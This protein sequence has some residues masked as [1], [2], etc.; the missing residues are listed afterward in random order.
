MPISDGLISARQLCS[1]SI[2]NRVIAPDAITDVEI[3]A[4]FAFVELVTTLPVSGNFEGRMVY[5]TTDDKLYRHDGSAFLLAVDG[6]DITAATISA[7]SMVA[8]TLT[9][10]EIS[11]GAIGASEL[12]AINI[13]VAKF[14]RSTTY[15]PGS[16]GWSID[17]DGTAEFQDVTVRGTI[18]A[19]S[20]EGNVTLGT[21]GVFRTAASG[22]RLEIT[23][24]AD[25]RVNFYSAAGLMGHIGATEGASDNLKIETDLG[26][27]PTLFLS[28]SGSTRGQVILQANGEDGDSAVTIV[29][30]GSSTHAIGLKVSGFSGAGFQFIL[31]DHLNNNWGKLWVASEGSAARP[32]YTWAGDDDTGMLRKTANQI[33]WATG[34]TERTFLTSGGFK[35]TTDNA[36]DLG[37]SAVTWRRLYVHDIYDETGVRRIQTRGDPGLLFYNESGT[38]RMSVGGTNVTFHDERFITSAFTATGSSAHNATV[39]DSSTFQEYR[40]TSHRKM[41]KNIRTMDP[42]LSSR[43]H[44]LDLRTFDMRKSYQTGAPWAD[45]DQHGMIADEVHKVFGDQAAAPD[46]NGEPGGWSDRFMTV[47]LISE[48]QK[49]RT[50]IGRLAARVARL[51]EALAA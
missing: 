2:D 3:A 15:T 6:A 21:G 45:L 5:L 40:F 23:Q 43:L 35:P 12:A 17:A 47:M 7:G 18:E 37:D 22:N 11:A 9:A 39:W 8:N 25:D 50:E 16:A 29:E 48:A 42:A 38:L 44:D 28:A 20:I 13:G 49:S 27:T 34:G 31:R 26:A 10:G 36:L 41:K 46:E 51:E 32:D 30:N 19:S 24:S 33:G 4:G 1:N 14:I